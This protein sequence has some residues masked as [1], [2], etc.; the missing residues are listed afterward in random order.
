MITAKHK[1]GTGSLR[2]HSGPC[3]V[4]GFF[5]YGAAIGGCL[6]LRDGVN[7]SGEAVRR[8]EPAE[9]APVEFEFSVP[10]EFKT[11]IYIDE[12]STGAWWVVEYIL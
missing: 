5:A 1:F 6:V 4:T 10:L 3:T 8:A 7:A 9:G 11:G 12:V 2:V